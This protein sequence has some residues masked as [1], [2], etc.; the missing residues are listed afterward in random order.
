MFLSPEDPCSGNCLFCRLNRP[1][2]C[3]FFEPKF[4]AIIIHIIE[5]FEKTK[6]GSTAYVNADLIEQ[7]IHWRPALYKQIGHPTNNGFV[8]RCVQEKLHLMFPGDVLMMEDILGFL[9]NEYV[10]AELY[11]RRKYYASMVADRHLDKAE[12]VVAFEDVPNPTKD[13]EMN[14][15][16]MCGCKF[17]YTGSCSVYDNYILS[18]SLCLTSSA[19]HDYKNQKKEPR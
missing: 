4:A 7:V 13:P 5:A 14:P 2:D 15:Q 17:Y 18:K 19:L 8:W 3:L 16:T 9:Q 11:H 12:E 1:H 10:E 6:L